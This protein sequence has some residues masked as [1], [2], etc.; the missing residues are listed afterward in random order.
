MTIEEIR[1]INEASNYAIT[2][3]AKRRMSE[4]NIKLKD[5]ISC[6]SG[7]KIIE[8]YMDDF[9]MPSYLILGDDSAGHYMHVVISTDGTLIYLITAYHPSLSIWNEDYTMR[10]K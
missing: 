1:K 3:H 10:R 9:P 4:R 6:V 5:V 8:S 2:E 7:G